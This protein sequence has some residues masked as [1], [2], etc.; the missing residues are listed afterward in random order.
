MTREE[1]RNVCL[2]MINGKMEEAAIVQQLEDLCS[3][4]E[5]A[6]EI[7]GFSDAII[8]NA[9]TI[10][11]SGFT[12]DMCGTGGSA[13]ERFN[14]STCAAFVIS[15][16]GIP[17][18]KHGNRG[19]KKANGSFDLLEALGIDIDQ[20]PEQHAQGLND[21]K[22]TFIFARK[23][24]PAMKN[25]AGARK[26]LGKRS[27]FN[28]AGPLSNPTNVKEQI[29]GVSNPEIAEKMLDAARL[30]GKEKVSIVHGEPGIDEISVSGISYISRFNNSGM[31]ILEIHP[32]QLG[33]TPVHYDKLPKG[34]VKTNAKL[35]QELTENQVHRGIKQMVAVNSALVLWN[36]QLCNTMKEGYQ[37]CLKIIESGEM[38]R[39]YQD[40]KTFSNRR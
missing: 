31:E 18:A 10:P 21:H 40:Y 9:L 28:M 12:V 5:S 4:G 2:E 37:R 22:L 17:V 23:A 36:S 26:T 39:K 16:F 7:A 24:H 8:E 35:F 29:I 25:V 14:V 20:S 30:L 1:A 11:Y 13:L 34:D 6:E 38:K 19:S 33:I 27:I 15:C 3:N 32:E